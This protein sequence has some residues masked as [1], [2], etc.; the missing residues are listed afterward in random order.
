MTETGA[1]I[2]VVGLEAQPHQ[3]LE[4]IGFLVGALGRAEAGQRLA[5]VF[6]AGLHQA[7]GG[8]LHRLFPGRLAEHGQ[9]IDPA[10]V[11]VAGLGSIVPADQRLGQPLGRHGVVEAEA[12]LHAQPVLV[13]EAVTAVDLDDA[14][15]LDHHLGLA[16]HAAERTDRVDFLVE[17]LHLPPLEGLVHQG[18]LV[19]GPG[20]A[21][22]DALAAG[23]AGR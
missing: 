11:S 23:D 19:E 21:G 17:V 16:A 18:L 4:Q 3:L 14:V 5:A 7:G 12:T 22:L 13:G 6:G 10:Q 1:V 8:A 2:D 9:G 15:V 20:R